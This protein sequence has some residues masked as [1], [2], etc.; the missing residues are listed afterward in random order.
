MDALYL[1][2]VIY[3]YSPIMWGLLGNHA[4][5][6]GY[7][8]I[9]TIAYAFKLTKILARDERT[10]YLL[11]VIFAHFLPLAL[12]SIFIEN[13][14][15]VTSAAACVLLLACI[16]AAASFFASPTVK[17]IYKKHNFFRNVVENL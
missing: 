13:N 6:H 3:L 12:Y 5:R 14:E 15:L 4:K 7:S 2:A 16:L 10:M 8:H 17:A 11:A 9:S 1:I